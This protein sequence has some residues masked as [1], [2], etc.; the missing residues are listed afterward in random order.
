[1]GSGLLWWRGRCER[2][3][4]LRWCLWC[5]YLRVRGDWSVFRVVSKLH[6]RRNPNDQ[7]KRH[8]SKSYNSLSPPHQ[9]VYLKSYPS[10]TTLSALYV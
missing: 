7:I 9:T 5:R 10:P 8:T 3:L 4:M 2:S 1:M 6:L